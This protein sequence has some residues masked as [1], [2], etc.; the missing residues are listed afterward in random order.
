MRKDPFIFSFFRILL[1]S[2]FVGL[3]GMLYWSSLLVEKDLITIKKELVEIRKDLSERS[4]VSRVSGNPEEK[5][6]KS[7]PHMD[8]KLPNL[9][10]ED[11][12]YQTTLP[13]MLGAGFKPSGIRK[14]ASL[15]KPDSLHPFSSFYEAATWRRNCGVGVSNNIFGFFEK[16]ATGA[17]IKVEERRDDKGMEY[18]IH[19]REGMV[20]Q[21]LEQNWFP[22]SITLAPHFLKKHPLTA[23]DFK[24]YF[25]VVM[26]PFVSNGLAVQSRDSFEDI[27][28]V[29]VIDDLTFVVR[30]KV[31]PVVMPDGKTEMQP[32]YLSKAITLSFTPLAGFVYLYYPD[33]K[34]IIEDDSNPDTYRLNSTFAQTMAEH[35][36][37]NIIPSCGPIKFRGM[38]DRMVR[39]DRNAD[40]YEPLACLVEGVEV[41]FKAAAE[42]IWQDFKQGSLDAYNLQPDQSLEFENFLKSPSYLAQKNDGLKI[43]RLDY[44]FRGFNYI[45]WNQARPLFASDKVRRALTMS[46]DRNRIIK[47]IL[48]GMG[49]EISAPFYPFS[50]SYD[51]SIKPWPY[52]PVAA[53][54]LLEEEGFADFDGDG[55]IEKKIGDKILKFEFAL[56]Y[57]VKNPTTKAICEYIST[58]LKEV[59]IKCNLNGVDMADISNIFDDKNFDAYYLAWSLGDP[60]EDLRQI[61]HSSGAKEKGSP[62]S[63]GFANKEV[64]QIIDQLSFEYNREK[65]IALY[66]RFAAIFHEEAPYTL[67][68]TI[69]N[70]MV[71][72]EFLQNVFLPVDRQDLI[73]GAVTAE[74][75]PSIFWIKK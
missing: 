35:W 27:L 7:R 52:D 61:W 43:D 17:A 58:A 1:L 46:I 31:H 15:G 47:Q 60:P 26:N 68:Y 5:I 75:E 21:P 18:W 65:R 63:I 39:F 11:P 49:I 38:T 57:Y 72:R 51:P 53:K 13:K 41:E 20:W 29:R 48:N 24:L 64:D 59:G 70:A 56:T 45:G 6:V 74:P 12:F 62:N 14:Q 66:H 69:K 54:R 28:E 16:Y 44:V 2:L 10:E 22:S 71:Y 37:K 33:G 73:P 42:N 50:D 9:L 36:A 32:K 19:L 34:K 4:L 3:M 23:H 25:D 67:L 40:F 55:I 30:W 8:L